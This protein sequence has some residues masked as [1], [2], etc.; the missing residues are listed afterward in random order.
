M[1]IKEKILTH[2]DYDPYTY[3]SKIMYMLANNTNNVNNQPIGV[4][5]RVKIYHLLCEEIG[6]AKKRKMR[7]YKFN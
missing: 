6:W 5:Q 2:I 4:F 3:L 7:E 1:A